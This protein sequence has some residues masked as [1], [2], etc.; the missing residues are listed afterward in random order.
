MA[1]IG[2]GV[3]VHHMFATPLPQLGQGLFTASSLMIA[4]PNGV[5]FFC[6]IATLWGGR[7][8]VRM[9]MLFVLGFFATFLI[10]GLTGVMLASVSIN[11]QVHDTFFVVA[12]LH[13]VLIGGA[14][15]PLFGAFYYWFPKWTGRMLSERIGL[16]EL[17]PAVRRLPPDVLPACTSS[18]CTGCPGASTPTPPRPAGARS[19]SLATFGAFLLGLGVLVFLF[20]VARS[21]RRG[22]IAGPNPWGAGTLE[23]ATASPPPSYNFLHP[24]TVRSDEPLWEDP[25]DTPVVVGLK[26]DVRE[27]LVTT[28]NE[29][30]PRP[31]AHARRRL[32][33]AAA[34]GPGRRRVVHRVRLPPRRIPDR[35]G[36]RLRRPHRLVLAEARPRAPTR[37]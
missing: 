30:H 15:F 23:W 33:L 28:A 6:W 10:G 19:T 8:Y 14:I 18:A 4:I 16:V 1:F 24:P 26:T 20:N 35:G 22:R 5:Q 3:W 11:T 25:A 17:R 31:A 12:H 29:A 37:R 36:D 7:P 9:P 32:D 13:Y 21:R 34:P 2:F 27:V